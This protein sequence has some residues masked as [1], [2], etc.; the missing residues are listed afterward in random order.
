MYTICEHWT[1]CLAWLCDNE[2]LGV[3]PVTAWLQLQ[4]HN[5]YT[6]VHYATTVMSMKLTSETKH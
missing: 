5:K 2:R 6:M 4:H 3:E 1:T